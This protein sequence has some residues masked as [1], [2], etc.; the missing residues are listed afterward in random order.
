MS[1]GTNVP[2]S[3]LLKKEKE[4]LIDGNEHKKKTREEWRK[5]K[6]LEELRKLASV[7]PAQDE[8]GNDINPHIP[9]YISTTPWYYNMTGT[10]LTHQRPQEEKQ[11]FFH[12]YVGCPISLS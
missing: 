9:Q 7:P 3:T 8:L 10:T 6:E 5:E 2:I 12:R 1:G 11:H 4:G